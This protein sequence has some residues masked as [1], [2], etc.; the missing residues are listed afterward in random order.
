MKSVPYTSTLPEDVLK[1]LEF[2]AGKF[3]LPK[4]KIIEQSLIAYFERLKQAE[5]VHSFRKAAGDAQMQE[6][7]EENLSDYLKILDENETA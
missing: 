6:M 7:A 2:Y 1:N 3:R 5:Y 4:N